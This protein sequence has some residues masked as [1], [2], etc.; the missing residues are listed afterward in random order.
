MQNVISVP[1]AVRVN[2]LV[3]VKLFSLNIRCLVEIIFVVALFLSF[4]WNF[5]DKARFYWD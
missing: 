5:I 2:C 1:S 3:L 4:Q